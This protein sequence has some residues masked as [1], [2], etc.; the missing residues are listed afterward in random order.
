MKHLS[1]IVV[2]TWLLMPA[3]LLAEQPRKNYL[4]F[5]TG[6]VFNAD[7]TLTVK[8]NGYPD[9]T[10]DAEFD[11]KPFTDPIYY[12]LRYGR[13]TGNAAWEIELIHDKLYVDDTPPDIQQFEIT[14]GFNLL[15]INRAWNIK[16]IIYRVG[17]GTVITHPDITVR[18]ET[19]FER[20]GGAIPSFWE[21]G[22]HWGGIALQGAIQKRFFVTKNTFFTLE[23][24]LVY[25]DTDVPIA[26]GSVRVKN[27][28]AH[29]LF[30]YGG[31]F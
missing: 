5:S 19:N 29:F 3:L 27:Q 21:D 30:G 15:T 18:G 8:Q 7:Q 31:R 11:T 23:A 1:T 12:A 22:Y 13:W 28:S 10:F 2:A 17:I 16:D 9:I 14:D 4:E 26:D 6:Y 25:A 20:G 24:K